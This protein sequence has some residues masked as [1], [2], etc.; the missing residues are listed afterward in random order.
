MPDREDSKPLDA[1]YGFGLPIGLSVVLLVFIVGSGVLYLNT[2]TLLDNSELIQHTHHVLSSLDRVIS[3]A[4]D[5]ETGQ[6]VF[7]HR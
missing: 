1:L 4:K 6:R 2:R 3:L 7:D 5:A